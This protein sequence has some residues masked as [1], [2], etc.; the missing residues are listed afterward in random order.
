MRVSVGKRL[1]SPFPWAAVS[2]FP[3]VHELIPKQIGETGLSFPI[4]PASFLPHR[5]FHPCLTEHER[6]LY[7][8]A[9]S[10]KISSPA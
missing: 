3:R 4:N 2:G 6:A 9:Q 10:H 1:P 8:L 7:Q 5:L